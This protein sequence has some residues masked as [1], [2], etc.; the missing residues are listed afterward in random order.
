ML[1]AGAGTGAY[2][3]QQQAQQ[4]QM[5][6]MLMAKLMPQREPGLAPDVQGPTLQPG[7][8]SFRNQMMGAMRGMFGGTP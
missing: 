6:K 1:A 8:V 2:G 3:G 7:G 5:M 4:D